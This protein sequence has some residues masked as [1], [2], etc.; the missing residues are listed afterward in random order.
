MRENLLVVANWKSNKTVSES[1]DWLKIFSKEKEKI[2][3]QNIEVVICPSFTALF[4]C[5]RFIDENR[6]SIKLGGQNI[7]EFGDG[8]YTGEV[9]ARQLKESADYVII[10]H[11][12]RKKYVFESRHSMEKKAEQAKSFG[13]FSILCVDDENDFVMPDPS[14]IAYEPPTAISTFGVGKAD[15]PL[16][17][18]Q[19]FLKLRKKSGAKLLYGG[20]IDEN[21][22]N[23]YLVIENLSGFLVGGASL[24]PVKFLNL[25]AKC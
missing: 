4:A 13:I 22:I 23:S 25:L 19:V 3:L 18:A 12:E 9:S 20:S 10:G 21:N 2:N 11:S 1:L 24:D 6:L 7:S 14:Y 17:V 15:D 5:S 16:H 8:A